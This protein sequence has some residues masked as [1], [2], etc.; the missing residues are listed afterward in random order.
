V[1]LILATRLLTNAYSRWRYGAGGTH[2]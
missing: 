1:G 2:A